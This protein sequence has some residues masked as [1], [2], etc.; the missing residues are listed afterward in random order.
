MITF[1]VPTENPCTIGGPQY[2]PI[3]G[4][5]N[6]YIQCSLDRMFVKPCPYNL[7]WN[8][9]V[10]ACDWPTVGEYPAAGNTDYGSSYSYGRKK[11]S[12]A[13]RKKRHMGG[14]GY[15]GRGSGGSGYGGRD[16][17]YGGRGSGY[18]GRGFGGPIVSEVPLG[19][20]P[21]FFYSNARYTQHVFSSRPTCTRSYSF[22][23]FCRPYWHSRSSHSTTILWVCLLIINLFRNNVL[24]H[25][26]PPFL[27]PIGPIPY[28]VFN[29]KHFFS[30]KI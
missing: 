7:V 30:N 22:T 2:Y 24:T 6:C 13:E 23:G 19:K 5:P 4:A 9:R 10:N 26:S 14:S 20:H 17:G 27:P 16:S 28:V 18:G 25:F 11:R 1:L 21:N 8:T 12:I 29:I 15:G 3:P